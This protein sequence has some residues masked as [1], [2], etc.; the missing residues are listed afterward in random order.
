MGAALAAVALLAACAGSK[1][2]QKPDQV[3][4]RTMTGNLEFV[5]SQSLMITPQEGTDH[6]AR[7]LSR[8]DKVSVK[9]DGQEV[10]W[11]SLSQGDEVRVVYKESLSGPSEISH[12]EILSAGANEPKEETTPMAPE[13]TE[14]IPGMPGPGS[15]DMPP[16]QPPPSLPQ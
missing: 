13:P 6:T 11:D 14:P 8:S 12:V 3:A 9:Q 15:S 5:D 10:G 1:A 4:E 2:E 16:E 7:L